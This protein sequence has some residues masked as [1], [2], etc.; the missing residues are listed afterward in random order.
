MQLTNN[1][2]LST[3]I[4]FG[5]RAQLM[6]ALG[7]LTLLTIGVAG[8]ALWGV[9][10]ITASSHQAME[11]DGRMSRLASQIAIQTLLT[12]RYEKDVFINIA[13]AEARSTA[14]HNWHLADADLKQAIEAFAAFATTAE[15]QQ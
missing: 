4:H 10:A 2:T 12:R 14:D 9:A 15:D 6:L 1:T 5:L 13:D 8:A 7:L 3:R 11:V